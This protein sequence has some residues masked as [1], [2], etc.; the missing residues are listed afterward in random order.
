MYARV[1]K[2]VVKEGMAA[3]AVRIVTESIA[4]VAKEQPGN[5]GYVVLSAGDVG[6]TISFWETKEDLLESDKNGYLQAQIA[7]TASLLTAPSSFEIYEVEHADLTT[8]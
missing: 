4:P 2:S 1:I 3:E 8:A 6:L 5:R 7:K